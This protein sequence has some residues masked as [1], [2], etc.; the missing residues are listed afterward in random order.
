[1]GFDRLILATN[2]INK[3]REIK[4]ILENIPF[5]LLTIEDF[6]E[7]LTMEVIEDGTTFEEN[8]IKKAKEISERFA[9]PALADDSGLEIAAL[10]GAPGV[11][12]SRYL[13][14][15]TPYGIKNIEIINKLAEL[16]TKDRD[17]KF[18]CVAAIAW[19]E[20]PVGPDGNVKTFRG[21]CKGEISNEPHGKEGFGYDPIFWL[22]EFGKTMAELSLAEK[23]K[24]SHRARCFLQVRKYLIQRKLKS[25]S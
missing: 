2:N 16:K 6:P 9:L 13:G 24:I 21:E 10:D 23:N 8:A 3:V 12:S 11:Q 1:M 15:D 5:K 17:A 4:E 18:V 25:G 7:L 22:S 20:V 19:P 14:E